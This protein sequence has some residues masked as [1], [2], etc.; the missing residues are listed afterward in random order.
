MPTLTLN[1][2]GQLCL[3]LRGAA[4]DPILTTFR[5]WPHWRDVQIE[6]DPKTRRCVAVTLITDVTYEPTVRAILKRSFQLVFPDL[7]S[8]GQDQA[9]K[10]PDRAKQ[11][12]G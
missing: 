1:Q 9:P 12:H 6:R 7:P 5:H 3:T 8:Q 10:L 4:D 2:R 11:R